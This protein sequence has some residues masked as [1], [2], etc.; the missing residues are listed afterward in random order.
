MIELNYYA[1]YL[2][3]YLQEDGSRIIGLNYDKIDEDD[4]VNNRAEDAATVYESERRNGA[5]AY[6]AQEL[7]MAVL[8]EGLT[9]LKPT[10]EELEIEEKYQL[11]MAEEANA[12]NCF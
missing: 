2:K 12:C 6:Q 3:K 8:L 10:R 11:E 1:L 7:A 5:S 9:D 4:F